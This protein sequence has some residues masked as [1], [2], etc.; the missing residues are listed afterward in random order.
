LTRPGP[1]I[2]R[3]HEI[4]LMR[5][6]KNAMLCHAMQWRLGM[7][8]CKENGS[9]S[10][11]GEAPYNPDQ[12]GAGIDV[13][14]RAETPYTVCACVCSYTTLILSPTILYSLTVHRRRMAIPCGRNNAVTE[15]QRSRD[16]K[17]GVQIRLFHVTTVFV[18]EMSDEG[19]MTRGEM[20]PLSQRLCTSGA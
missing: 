16:T 3:P 19:D 20:S 12:H 4:L 10:I 18:N 7:L 11:R 17:M 15:Q 1:S 14:C 9:H 2:F 6:S 8:H 13:Q 5:A